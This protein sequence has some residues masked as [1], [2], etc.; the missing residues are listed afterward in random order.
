MLSIHNNLSA[1]TQNV[2]G[3]YVIIMC[4]DWALIHL[5]TNYARAYMATYMHVCVPIYKKVWITYVAILH[6]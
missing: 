4:N 1:G 2:T 3:T 6:T 5:V